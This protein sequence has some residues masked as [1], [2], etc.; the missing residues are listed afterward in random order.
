[1]ADPTTFPEEHVREP[2]IYR[3]ISGFAIAAIIVAVSYALIVLLACIA[4]LSE[5]TPVLLSPWLQVLAVIGAGLA[6]AAWVQIHRSEGTV[7]G[8]KLALSSL[9]LS[10]FFGLGYGAYY[11]ATYLAIRY[12]ADTFVQGWFHKLQEG[13]INTAFLLT[14]DP[15]QRKNVNPEDEEGINARFPAAGMARQMLGKTPLEVFREN[16]VV[17]IVFQGGPSTRI[18]PLG[19]KDW[20]Y[21][22]GAYRVM[23]TYQIDTDEGA[24]EAQVIVKGTQSKT[25]E[26]E[27]RQWSITTGGLKLD[28]EE[29]SARG[30]EILALNEQTNQFLEEWG[31][32]LVSNLLEEAFL[33]TREP[34]ERTRLARQ[35]DSRRAALP[36]LALGIT[37][38]A[39]WA[40]ANFLVLTTSPEFDELARQ[41]L[42]PGYAEQ[43]HRLAILKTDKFRAGD[44]EVRDQILT[45]VKGMFAPV[46][47]GEPRLLA[48]K[49]GYIS[50]YQ[51]WKV[52]NAGR[53]QLPHDC[54]LSIGVGGKFKYSALATITLVSDPGALTAGR[55]PGWRVVSVELMNGEDVARN[56]SMAGPRAS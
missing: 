28:H 56:R 21:E 36:V 52:D 31:N 17:H 44:V 3:P 25:R 50:G 5:A 19:V 41:L 7:A 22:A 27:G 1:M 38:V 53:V 55:K 48:L 45:A 8:M 49:P 40:G 47:M 42:L 16:K 34:A 37:T 6:I 18:T 32:K 51:T 9:I 11:V 10:A 20:A 12:Q 2:L 24:F 43:F 35:Y 23:R 30:K 33:D 15:A 29:V 4:G 26:Y 13:K 39:P 54:R 46:R 14:Q